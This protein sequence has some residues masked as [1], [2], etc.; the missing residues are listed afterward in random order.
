MRKREIIFLTIIL[1]ISSNVIFV[2][3][4][5]LLNEEINVIPNTIEKRGFEISQMGNVRI[6]V[7]IIEG[8]TIDQLVVYNYDI[9]DPSEFLTGG[10]EINET[11]TGDFKWEDVSNQLFVIE[12]DIG[13]YRIKWLSTNSSKV[14]M[15]I[16]TIEEKSDSAG[17]ELPIIYM[18]AALTISLLIIKQYR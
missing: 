1:I 15:E 11:I 6:D 17:L 16:S 4:E 10:T 13:F 2:E 9:L 14:K 5:I 8:N 7:S 3:A 12:L 18:F